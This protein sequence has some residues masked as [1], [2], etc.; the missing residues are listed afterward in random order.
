MK[1]GQISYQGK[2]T[3][4]TIMAKRKRGE[5]L[6]KQSASVEFDFSEVDACDSSALALIL[7]L[8]RAALQNRVTISF[9]GLP[10]SLLD[11]AK[12]YNLTQIVKSH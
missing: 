2:L 7:A 11:L 8:Q 1:A 3:F 9:A 10:Q 12:L 5:A 4:G 6:I